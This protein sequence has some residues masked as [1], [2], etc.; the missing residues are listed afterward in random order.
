MKL[1][2]IPR[3]DL[4]LMGYDDIAYIILQESKKKMKLVDIFKKVCTVLELPEITVESQLVDF[5]E[6]MSINK[7]FTMLENGFWDLQSRHNVDILIEDGDDDEEIVSSS[8][9]M[10]DE[11]IDNEEDDI[12]Y[13]K[14]E[15]GDDVT[16]DDLTDLMVV[17]PDEEEINE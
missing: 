5:F 7:K 12:F 10:D 13:D 8:D 9:D 17:D 3:E 16:D 2:E 6:L 4:E 14:D 1:S 15:D 11:I